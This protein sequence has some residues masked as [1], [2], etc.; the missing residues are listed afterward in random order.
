MGCGAS[1]EKVEL[2]NGKPD[3]KYD[4]IVPSFKENG[5]GLLFRLVNK[6]K[7]QWAYYNDTKEYEMHVKVTFAKGADIK[8][9][10]KA[11]VETQEDGGYLATLVIYPLETELFVEGT[12]LEFK[13]NC[14][15]LPLSDEYRAMQAEK[16][17]K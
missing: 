1:G 2:L 9:L 16:K 6:K 7:K 3:F 12:I 15:A 14:E 11:H 8:A 4:V 17:K 10:G 5:N 13:V